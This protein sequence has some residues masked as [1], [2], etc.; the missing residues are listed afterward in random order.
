MIVLGPFNSVYSIILW[1]FPVQITIL[2]RKCQH[3]TDLDIGVSVF[4][5]QSI[6]TSEKKTQKVHFDVISSAKFLK[7]IYVKK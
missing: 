7:L 5:I 3:W 4:S 6:S 2:N 1:F